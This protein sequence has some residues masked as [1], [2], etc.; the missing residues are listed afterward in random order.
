MAYAI[1]SPT[2]QG[3]LGLV[4]SYTLQYLTKNCSSLGAHSA[5]PPVSYEPTTALHGLECNMH[6]KA[7]VFHR[8]SHRPSVTRGLV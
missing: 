5:C 7:A 3:R 6:P 4:E 8:S 2:V 1:L